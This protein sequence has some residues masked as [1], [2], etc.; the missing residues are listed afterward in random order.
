MKAVRRVIVEVDLEEKAKI[1]GSELL[2]ALPE[3][4]DYERLP[5]VGILRHAPEGCKIPV[6]A[7]VYYH[8][9]ACSEDQENYPFANLTY[10]DGKPHYAFGEH[11]IKMYEY[12]GQ[13]YANGVILMEHVKETKG[14]GEHKYEVPS[15]S[16]ATVLQADLG[17]WKPGDTFK[18]LK[19]F[20][21]EIRAKNKTFYYLSDENAILEK[22]GECY[23]TWNKIDEKDDYE[24]RNGILAKRIP[25]VTQHIS[26]RNYNYG[27]INR[28]AKEL[29]KKQRE[30]I[31]EYPVRCVYATRTL[32]N[33]EYDVV[34][35]ELAG[36]KV[37]INRNSKVQQGYIKTEDIDC[38]ITTQDYSS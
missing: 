28:L 31:E 20:D 30:I 26:K 12:E 29:N 7:E 24:M 11:L 22:N 1:E 37:L 35:G 9:D 33:L 25:T 34:G 4:N 23:K 13:L 38:I 16:E 27:E 18:F 6:G 5:E 21:Y 19:H 17:E 8:Y 15:P 3:G 2:G 36:N 32:I 10:I 14:W